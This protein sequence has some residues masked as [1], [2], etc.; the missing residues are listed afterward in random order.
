[1]QPRELLVKMTFLASYQLCLEHIGYPIQ[2][3][4][5]SQSAVYQ[6]YRY[7]ANNYSYCIFK[8]AHNHF[9]QI[10]FSHSIARKF[11]CTGFI[12]RT[13]P[14]FC[15]LFR[16]KPSRNT[17]SLFRLSLRLTQ[18]SFSNVPSLFPPNYFLFLMYCAID[19]CSAKIFSPSESRPL[20]QICTYKKFFNLLFSFI[21]S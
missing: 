14:L 2:Y 21:I 13:I 17:S 11:G 16:G 18:K 15:S 6:C 20:R 9:L 19:F 12:R 10:I 5:K 7:R 3:F 4:Y 8:M 1:M